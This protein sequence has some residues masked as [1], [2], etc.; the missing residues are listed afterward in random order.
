MHSESDIM[1]VVRKVKM[2]REKTANK[3]VFRDALVQVNAINNGNTLITD[4][5]RVKPATKATF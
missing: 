4:F 1:E 5:V 3:I 2:E